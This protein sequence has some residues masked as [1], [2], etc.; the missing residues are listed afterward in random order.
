MPK[1]HK[2][3][4]GECISH[5]AEKQGHIP[6][7]I[8][9]D[10]LNS[11]LKQKRKDPNILSEKDIVHVPDLEIKEEGCNSG[12]R[13]RFERKGICHSFEPYELIIDIQL[14][15][16]DLEVQDDIFTLYSTD[17]DQS[18]FEVLTIKNDIILDD[19]FVTLRF[20]GLNPNLSYTLEINPGKGYPPYELF[21]DIKY[22]ELKKA[23]EQEG[24][25]EQDENEEPEEG[26]FKEEIDE[27]DL[28]EEMDEKLISNENFIDKEINNEDDYFSIFED[29]D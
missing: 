27:F 5:I 24:H 4:R 3:K 6:E 20:T 12:Q 29:E 7:K 14:D 9:D 26:W 23:E 21:T 17:K 19:D 22:D 18:Y 11:E 10:P 15:P 13:H 25:L 1:K 16:D 2:V 8:W 28:S